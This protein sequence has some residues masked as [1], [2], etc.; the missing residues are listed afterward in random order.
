MAAA[1]VSACGGTYISA[2]ETDI[3]RLGRQLP[4]VDLIVECTGG[5]DAVESGLSLLGANGVLVL[6]S[7]TG[8]SRTAQLPIDKINFDFVTGNR[9]MVGSV[10]STAAD[11][12]AAIADLVE[13]ER[14]W[15]GLCSRL[16]T[17]R[18]SSLAEAVGLMEST[19]GSIK[20]IVELG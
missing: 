1:I 6:L 15:P 2:T 5:T 8:G 16:I 9:T 10:N 13:F 19:R 11:F 20:A 14:R 18:L 4:N 7:V 17:H 12:R 3:G